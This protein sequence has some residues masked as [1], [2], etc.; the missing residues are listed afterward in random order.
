M[1][2]F[3][4]P[5]D[6]H[7]PVKH[8]FSTYVQRWAAFKDPTTTFSVDSKSCRA[9]RLFALAHHLNH[10]LALKIY[11]GFVRDGYIKADFHDDMDL[12]VYVDDDSRVPGIAKAVYDWAVKC[13]IK[14]LRGKPVFSHLFRIEL[15]GGTGHSPI[16]IDLVSP[17]GF[18]RIVD[19]DVNSMWLVKGAIQL[20]SDV[21]TSSLNLSVCVSHYL[22]K[23]MVAINPTESF[24]TEKMKRRLKRFVQDR[25][26]KLIKVLEHTQNIENEFEKIAVCDLSLASDDDNRAAKAVDFYT[27]DSHDATMMASLVKDE[28]IRLMTETVTAV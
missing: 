3:D 4:H 21:D 2:S 6:K 26:W 24:K 12:D 1:L 18:A 19:F 7:S 20:R 23:E 16:Q 15:S 25:D 5:W 14:Y 9:I 28:T 13:G 10:C 8:G 17:G 22:R 11:G 27:K